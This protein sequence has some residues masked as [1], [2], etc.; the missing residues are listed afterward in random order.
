MAATE[1][2]LAQGQAGEDDL[3]AL[4]ALLE[5]EAAQ[6]LL[7][8]GARGE[9]AGMQRFAEAIDAGVVALPILKPTD[10]FSEEEPSIGEHAD[11]LMTWRV[12]VRRKQHFAAWLRCR[13]ELVE[14]A[15][16]PDAEQLVAFSRWKTQWGGR[17]ESDHM[18]ITEMFVY[19]MEKFARSCRRSQARLRCASCAVAVERFRLQH[20]RWPQ[21]LVELC[22]GF[23]KEV[24]V[25][26][27]AGQPLRF[28]RLDDGVVIY[29]V[30]LDGI[31]NGGN[32]QRHK[33]PDEPGTDLGFQLW[34]VEK[35]RQSPPAR[36]VG[37]E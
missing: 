7:L 9:R 22:P 11:W 36:P 2:V 33:S 25:D 17:E 16:L 1:R 3:A 5:D 37:K 12:D 28:R 19:S 29:S 30:G 13:T 23:L 6:P 27:F 34:D 18:S 14:V 35:R 24:P 4:Q 10:L 32:V 20:G 26:P 8:I 31:D 15:K 21:R